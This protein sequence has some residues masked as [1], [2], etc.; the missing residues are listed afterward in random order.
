MAVDNEVKI[1]IS[2]ED[3]AS[4]VFNSVG[5]SMTKLSD[6]T[7]G[8]FLKMAA[9]VTA[10]KAATDFLFDSFK[11]YADAE[12]EM[13][14]ANQALENAVGSMT[15]AQR[16]SATG[17]ADS[18]GALT[19]LKDQMGE[20]GRAA[21]QL[22]FD[23][24][25][26][27]VAFAKLVQV[28]GSAKQAQEDLKLAMDLSAFSGRSLEESAGAITK[29]HAGAT[30]VLKEFGIEVKEGTTSLEALSLLHERTAGTAEKMSKSTAGQLQVLGIEWKNLQETV[31]GALAQ[32]ITPFITS[33]N[34]WASKPETQ[35]KIQEIVDAFAKFIMQIGQFLQKHWPEFKYA[36]QVM[37]EMLKIVWSTLTFVWQAFQTAFTWIDKFTQ[38]VINAVNWV[39]NLI[40]KL[41]NLIKT[42][43]K[44][45]GAGLKNVGSALTAPIDKVMGFADGGIV[46]GAIGAPML[47]VVHGGETVIPNG[48]TGAGSNFNIYITGNSILN[49]DMVDRIGDLLM[50]KLKMQ[51]RI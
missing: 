48:A 41:E 1:K 6:I 49:D 36:L 42:L 45:A 9:V 47:A 38:S 30:R 7:V 20:V 33:L 50:G 28:S 43:A 17:I 25:E 4:G 44:A 11:A 35:Q 8:S 13:V 18:A 46:P 10:F 29:V 39:S 32:A 22:G 3:K 16:K 19:K 23:D 12:K 40:D 14:V 34:E 24:E 26:A 51:L 31:G 2:A 37:G 21:I 27:S 15:D 5:G